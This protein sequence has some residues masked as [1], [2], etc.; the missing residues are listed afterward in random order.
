MTGNISDN[1]SLVFNRSDSPTPYAGAIAG[2]GS[3]TQ[4]GTG[5]LTL[6]GANTYSGA[7]TINTGGLA[8]TGSLNPATSVTITG[9][10]GVFNVSGMTLGSQA[11]SSL[12]G[13]AN[14]S[15]ILG[16][17]TLTVGGSGVNTTFAGA[18]SGATGNFTKVG[19]ETLTLSGANTFGG[20][21]SLNAGTLRATNSAQAL[22]GGTLTLNGGVL[23][24]ANDTGLAFNRNTLVSASSTIVIDRLTAGAGVIDTLGTLSIGSQILTVSAGPLVTSGTAG[25]TFRE[26]F[27]DGGVTTFNSNGSLYAGGVTTLTALGGITGTNASLSFGTSSNTLNGT[28][29]A[30]S[31]TVGGITTGSGAVTKSGAGTLTITGAG[32]SIFLATIQGGTLAVASG[33]S[34]GSTQLNFSGS[35]TFVYNFPSVGTSQGM[36]PLN[37]TAGDGTVQSIYGTSGNAVLTFASRTRAPGATG[38]FVV[39]GGTAATNKIVLTGTT[40]NAFI[41]Q[42]TF[43]GGSNYAWYD[44]AG[45]VRGINY[46]T[47]S[48]TI[49]SSTTTNITGTTSS[50]NL[51][52]TGS[53]TAVLNSAYSTI[54]LSGANTNITITAGNTLTTNGILKGGA[55]TSTIATGT[56]TTSTSGA[57]L[58]VRTDGLNDNLVISSV[59]GALGTN[60][61]VKSGNGTLTLSG[62]NT[63]TG[64]VYLNGGTT[65][66]TMGN[67]LTG[68]LG[69]GS[70]TA[71]KQVFFNNN[72]VFR[73]TVS[74]DDNATSGTN[75]G[76]VFNIGAGGGTLDVPTGTILKIDTGSGSG[77]A[78]TNSQLQ[79][80]GDL[81]KT[82]LGAL[83][84]GGASSDFT[85]FSGQI[86]V[87]AG[88]VTIG[89]GSTN[90]LG[91][92]TA[93]TFIA[94]G[95]AVDFNGVTGMAEPFVINGAGLAGTPTGVLTNS[96][97]TAV[98]LSG[99]I[100]LAGNSSIGGVGNM[101]LSGVISDSGLGFGLTKVGADTL[102]LS[103]PSRTACRGQHLFGGDDDLRG[104]P[105]N[106][107]GEQHRQ[108]CRRCDRQRRPRFQ[109]A[110]CRDLQRGHFRDRQCFANWHRHVDPHQSQQLHGRYD[111]RRRFDSPL[112]R[113]RPG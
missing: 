93:G 48:G 95:A 50:T 66:T 97:A 72:A 25:L 105:A 34:L 110:R 53:L 59:I 91:S 86:F 94:S 19:T 41:D 8:L 79:G 11:I 81:T 1:A 84:L 46:G 107:H 82:G 87:N 36:G 16:A 74:F 73:S 96:S 31:I 106:R 62:V 98:A 71:Y 57:D 88:L 77:T 14:S 102:T 56:V 12:S 100:A 27:G 47:D 20:V 80:T 38:N 65:I 90:A 33:G 60:N 54:N 9:G 64:D 26:C 104:H 3:V 68:N 70:G 39:S 76:I 69:T 92:T 35:G 43:F 49:V 29:S 52:L 109:P 6:A 2:T 15:V 5:T 67:A 58:V 83:T 40:A 7:T 101:T 45:F 61:L 111:D 30:G 10:T 4:A 75:L 24:L 13:V 44:A 51:L 99:P 23:D 32:N 85:T 28:A 42:G 78:Q 113:R 18:I 89:S 103:G 22:G 17:K 63:F 37:F 112:W 55:G 108:H 21:L